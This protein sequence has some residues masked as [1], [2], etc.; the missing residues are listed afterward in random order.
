MLIPSRIRHLRTNPIDMESIDCVGPLG[1]IE[2]AFVSMIQAR[3]QAVVVNAESL[4]YQ[5]KEMIA[6]LAMSGR[7]PTCV[8][9]KEMVAVGALMSYGTDQC[10]IARRV[11]VYVDK[12]LKGARP[13][14]LPVEQP[15][16]Y[17]LV[18][19]LK[20]AKELGIA[21][22]QMVLAQASDVIE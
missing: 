14:E 19:N 9:V 4:F 10:A 7:L 18:I 1:G 8:W 3:M 5:G 16:E 22:P 20:T 6:K 21:V 17:E 12:I 2:Q 15:T 11:P 13:S